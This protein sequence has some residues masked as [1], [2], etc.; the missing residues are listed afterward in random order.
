MKAWVLH[1]INDIR[2]DDVPAPVIKPNE[3]LIRVKCASICTS[4]LLRV[5]SA[6][7]YHY[8][9]ILGHEVSG[10]VEECAQSEWIGKRVSIFPLIPCFSCESCK[11]GHFE[12]CFHY[13]YIG[14]RQDGGFAEFVAVPIWNLCP[15]PD[16]VSFEEAALF[17]PA[18]VALHAAKMLTHFDVAE[19]VAVIGNGVIGLLVA[20]WLYML[21]VKNAQVYGRDTIFKDNYAACFEAVGSME[22]METCIDITKPN[23]QL[24]LVG[25]PEENFSMD[26]NVYW[27]ILRKQ[28][29]I[30]GSWNSC[31]QTDWNDVVEGI[32]KLELE[33]LISHRYKLT[34]LDKA[35]KMMYE[36]KEKRYKVVV[37]NFC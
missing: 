36:G 23:G 15:I 22:S 21:G 24:I 27:K 32:A 37:N 2:L 18:A 26:R 12:T 25:N 13:S 28:L 11:E 8:P 29:T 35:L 31:K 34:D 33:N 20:R 4:D 10:V 3:A 9:L 14:S 19:N 16:I 17:E 1:G 7:A 6:G 30:R 5:Y